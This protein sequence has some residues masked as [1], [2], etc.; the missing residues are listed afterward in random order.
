MPGQNRERARGDLQWRERRAG[1]PAKIDQATIGLRPNYGRSGRTSFLRQSARWRKK[2]AELKTDD[3]PAPTSRI[4]LPHQRRDPPTIVHGDYRLGNRIVH[5]TEPR[6]VAVLDWELST[7]GHPLCA[8]A[9]NC[10][11]YHLPDPPPGFA[12]PTWVAVASDGAGL[13]GIAVGMATRQA[14]ET[15]ALGECGMYC[16][17]KF[18]AQARCVAY[19]FSETGRAEGFSAGASLQQVE[20]PA[21]AAVQCQRAGRFLQAEDG[22]LLRVE[23]LLGARHSVALFS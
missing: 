4:R 22:A 5:P 12:K 13:W 11:G 9:Y 17:L 3:S 14:A 7:L 19:A 20:Q 10:L 23:S 1:A 16:K 18:T 8:I 21:W 15:S 2:Y 6:I